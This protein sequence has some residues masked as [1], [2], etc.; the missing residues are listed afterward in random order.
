LII[1]KLLEA[2]H[3]IVL[4][5][6]LL[7]VQAGLES[8]TFTIWQR[9]NMHSIKLLPLTLYS[10]SRISSNL[11]AFGGFETASCWKE[12]IKSTQLTPIID[13]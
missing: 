11:C 6:K 9:K 5:M 2:S 7:P 12:A 1:L 3:Q 13:S 10:L 4:N 8:Q